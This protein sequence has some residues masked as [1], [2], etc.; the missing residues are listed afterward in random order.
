MF[1]IEQRAT[2]LVLPWP[3]TVNGMW[4]TTGTGRK[5]RTYL[6]DEGKNYKSTVAAICRQSGHMIYAAGDRLGYVLLLHP[7]DRRRRDASNYV[8]C[9]EDALTE[10]GVWPDDEQVDWFVVKKME[11]IPGG[12]AVITIVLAEGGPA[13]WLLSGV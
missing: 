9:V 13:Q 4:R 2:R 11:R 3:P 8:K 12:R 6:T 5:Q 1:S 7:P 10:A